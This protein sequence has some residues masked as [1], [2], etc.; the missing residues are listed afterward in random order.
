MLSCGPGLP[1]LMML[2][3]AHDE[4]HA[5]VDCKRWSDS[6]ASMH[7]ECSQHSRQPP[8]WQ[9]GVD[10]DQI[11]AFSSLPSLCL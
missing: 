8:T 7:A 10:A 4:S 3:R 11:A 9:D 1:E 5:E 2:P 6:E